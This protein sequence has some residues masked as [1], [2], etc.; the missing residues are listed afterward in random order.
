M[1]NPYE[2]FII[3]WEEERTLLQKLLLKEVRYG[4]LEDRFDALIEAVDFMQK[5]Y[6][7]S[8]NDW[9]IS[10]GGKVISAKKKNYNGKK[11]KYNIYSIPE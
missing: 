3:T 10:F 9:K 11:M 6:E 5:W 2:D 7:V 4:I 1:T 8:P